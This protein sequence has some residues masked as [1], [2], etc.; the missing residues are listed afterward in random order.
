[1]ELMKS[2]LAIG[3]AIILA[4]FIGYGVYIVYEPPNIR[5]SVNR[6]LDESRQCSALLDGCKQLSSDTSS[7]EYLDCLQDTREGKTYLDCL[8][9]VEQCKKDAAAEDPKYKHSRNSFFILISFVIVILVAGFL[10]SKFEGIGSGFLGGSIILTIWTLVYTARYWLEFNKYVKLATLG[11]IL[12]L[13][14]FFGYRKIDKMV[15][16]ATTPPKSLTINSPQ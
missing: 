6:C 1:M 8:E 14:I 13:L 12:A 7:Q 2:F 9:E 16:K 10:L 11:V 4:L 5:G 15:H 3:I